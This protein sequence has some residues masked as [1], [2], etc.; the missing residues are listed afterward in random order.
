M[1]ASTEPIAA[2]FAENLVRH[3]NAAK[4]SQEEL[5]DRAEIHRTQVSMIEGGKRMPRLDTLIKLAG[6]LGIDAAELLAGVRWEPV[7][8][9][10]GRFVLDDD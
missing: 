4:L 5:A 8:I 3:R 1:G 9:R 2:R 6:A 7:V 10:H